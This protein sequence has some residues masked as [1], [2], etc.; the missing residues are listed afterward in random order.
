MAEQVKEKETQKGLEYHKNKS[1]NVGN[2][3]G[4]ICEWTL[5][6]CKAIVKPVVRTLVQES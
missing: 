3:K 6:M 5:K 1:A 2:R 4:V